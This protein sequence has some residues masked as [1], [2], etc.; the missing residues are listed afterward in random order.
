MKLN[1]PFGRVSNRNQR[2]YQSL[3][4]RLHQEGIQDTEAVAAFTRNVT[5]TA[6][7]LL[8]L[9]F[10]ISLA[11][12]VFFPQFRAVLI[13]LNLLVLLWVCAVYFQ[14][15]MHLKRYLRE[16]CNQG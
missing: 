3:R 1:D 9:L 4:D 10:G 8:L 16:E 7:K 5:G 15:R 6:V 11:L 12:A 14:T 13:A 2:N